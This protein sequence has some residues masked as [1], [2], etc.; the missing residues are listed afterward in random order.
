[1]NWNYQPEYIISAA[2]ITLA[3]SVELAVLPR[4]IPISFLQIMVIWGVTAYGILTLTSWLLGDEPQ[5]KKI[6]TGLALTIIIIGM[7]FII[8]VLGKFFYQ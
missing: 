5:K 3:F 8:F 4:F 7:G 2:L 6:A 1:M